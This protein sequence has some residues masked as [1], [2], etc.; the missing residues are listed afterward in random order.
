MAG[1]VIVTRAD[2]ERSKG[3]EGSEM[4]GGAEFPPSLSSLLFDAQAPVYTVI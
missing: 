4:L 3:E 2:E 1:T